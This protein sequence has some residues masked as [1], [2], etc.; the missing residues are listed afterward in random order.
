[1]AELPKKRPSVSSAFVIGEEETMA[2]GKSFEVRD[3][4]ETVFAD[5][6]LMKS[7]LHSH[8]SELEQ[9]S[10]SEPVVCG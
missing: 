8:V 6:T 3:Y 1:M 7:K 4:C 5:L 2:T 9:V 10:G